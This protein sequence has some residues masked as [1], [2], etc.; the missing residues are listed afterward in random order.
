MLQLR[1]CMLQ[2]RS[3]HAATKKPACCNEDPHAAKKIQRATTKT[4]YSQ[5]K[6]KK[7]FPDKR[8]P[9]EFVNSR[10]IVKEVFQVEMKGH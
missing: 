6:K 8:K 7:V 10:Q 5:K 2:L 9:R 4:Q 3:P 1:V